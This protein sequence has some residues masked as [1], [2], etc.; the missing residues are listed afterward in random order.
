V[1]AIA[2]MFVYLIGIP[3]FFLHMMYP[4]R[5]LL[6]S[7]GTNSAKEQFRFFVKVSEVVNLFVPARLLTL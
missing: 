2:A 3:C 7:S 5:Q 4:H 1:L 6:Q